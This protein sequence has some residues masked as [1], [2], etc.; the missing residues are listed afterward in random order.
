M[1]VECNETQGAP[2]I[3]DVNDTI[4]F[5]SMLVFASVMP[6]LGADQPEPSVRPGQQRAGVPE[7]NDSVDG[8]RSAQSAGRFPANC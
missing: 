1:T 4:A 6:A 8:I 2:A 5:G 3:G 7:T